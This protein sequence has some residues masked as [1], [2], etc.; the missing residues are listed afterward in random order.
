MGS[1]KKKEFV[2]AEPT[3][4]SSAERLAEIDAQRKVLVERLKQE[5][6]DAIQSRKEAKFERN[7]FLRQ[8][9][10]TVGQIQ[11]SIYAYNRF[12]KQK[13]AES[14]IFALIA[15]IIADSAAKPQTTSE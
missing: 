7:A 9:D 10:A 6:R 13:K 1:Q 5:K 12:S 2:E 4:Q 14:G 15:A 11:E 3:E 8:Q